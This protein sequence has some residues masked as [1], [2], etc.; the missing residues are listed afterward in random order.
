MSRG[1][2]RWEDRVSTLR[3]FGSEPSGWCSSRCRRTSRSGQVHRVLHVDAGLRERRAER[4]A[5]GVEVD[6]QRRLGL[7]VE[8]VVRVRGEL[9]AVRK[10]AEVRSRA[11]P[12]RVGPDGPTCAESPPCS[13]SCRRT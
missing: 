9:G 3:R 5:E 11:C 1:W 13:P 4:A 12:R 6:R 7:E 10:L 8:R 2:E